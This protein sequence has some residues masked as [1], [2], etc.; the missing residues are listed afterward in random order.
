[1]KKSGVG[2]VRLRVDDREVG[3][4]T[5][6]RGGRLQAAH[7]IIT[8]MATALGCASTPSPAPVAAPAPPAPIAGPASAAA[9]ATS[10]PAPASGSEANA[11]AELPEGRGKQILMASCTSC[12]DL[13]EVTKFRGYYTRAQWRDIVLTMVDYGADVTK[14][15]IDVLADYLNE[16]LGRVSA[17][18]P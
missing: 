9:P 1:V 2:E 15:D 18:K 16:H 10:P 6:G 13:R 4:R 11:E 8:A 12:H 3:V 7:L 5:A 17:S 14:A